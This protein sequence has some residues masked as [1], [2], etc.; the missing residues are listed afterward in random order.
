[1]IQRVGDLEITYDM[2]F[3]RREWRIQ[4]I[5]W[6]LMAL[7]AVAA[8]LGLFGGGPLSSATAGKEGSDF[9]VEYNRFL[10]LTKTTEVHIYIQSDA[11]RIRFWMDR[12]Y[13][14]SMELVRTTPP[15]ERAETTS[16]RVYFVFP[17]SRP[18]EPVQITFFLRPLKSTIASGQIGIDNRSTLDYTQ[19]IYP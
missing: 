5:G 13:L 3:Q 12:D 15:V 4:R 2:D 10:R 18:G 16:D 8:L 17:Q 6:G 7:F 11:D 14:T 9:W 1:M 19:I